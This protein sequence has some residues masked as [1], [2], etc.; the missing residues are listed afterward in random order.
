MSDKYG[1]APRY[2]KRHVVPKPA[3]FVYW[4]VRDRNLEGELFDFVLVWY[5]EPQ[6]F[7]VGAGVEWRRL[8]DGLNDYVG[9][10]W[11]ADAFRIFGTVPEDD[12]ECVR[13]ERNKMLTF[14]PRAEKVAAVKEKK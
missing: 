9:S 2:Q 14:D 7:T 1:N 4:I 3:P 11:P 12:I 6:R 13:V 5:A 10:L 8:P